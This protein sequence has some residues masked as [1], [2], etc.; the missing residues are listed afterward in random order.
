MVYVLTETGKELF[1]IDAWVDNA[2][3]KARKWASERGYIATD[4]EIT[5]NG[6]MII[7]VY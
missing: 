1:S 7:W 4:I 6:N 2:E 3:K 5:M